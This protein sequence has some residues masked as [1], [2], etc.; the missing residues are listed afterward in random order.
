MAES[1]S[2]VSSRAQYA[3]AKA[4]NRATIT[5]W[6]KAGRLVLDDGGNVLVAESEAR[7][8][9][10]ADPSKAGVVDRHE[11][12]RGQAVIDLA[13]SSAPEAATVPSAE[14]R[15][16]GGSEHYG[17]RIQ[18]SAR[19]EAAEADMAEMKRDR[20][21][22]KL[23]DVEGTQKAMV[24]FAALVRQTYKAPIAEIKLRMA[25]EADPD[26]VGA[27]LLAWVDD[28][29]RAVSELASALAAQPTNTRQ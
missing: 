1:V 8:A 20:E 21:I 3:R 10:T 13:G 14:T 9:E 16:R 7:L 17:K 4:V 24:D 15:K 11:R 26:K 19:R 5:R 18:E 23:T 29:A 6:A 25:A 22:G 2:N 12:E 27:M 28:A